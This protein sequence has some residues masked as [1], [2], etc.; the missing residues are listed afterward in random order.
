MYQSQLQVLTVLVIMVSRTQIWLLKL[1]W[2]L[3]NW[4]PV[5]YGKKKKCNQAFNFDF[6]PTQSSQTMAICS[7]SLHQGKT[8]SQKN[9]EQRLI[10][11]IS[12]LNLNV[13][14]ECFQFNQSIYVFMLHVLC[15]HQQHC[16]II[17]YIIHT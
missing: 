10:L 16:S 5:F 8:E 15:S 9:L 13:I 14:N 11:P 7:F 4:W 6:G 17:R 12:I 1:K 3:P 2:M